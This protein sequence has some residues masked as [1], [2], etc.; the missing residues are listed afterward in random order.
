MA[1]NETKPDNKKAPEGAEQPETKKAKMSVEQ[2]ADSE[3]PEAWFVSIQWFF[4]HLLHWILDITLA[5][6]L[7]L[8]LLLLK[9][10]PGHRCCCETAPKLLTVRIVDVNSIS[11]LPLFLYLFCLLYSAPTKLQKMSIIY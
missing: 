6:R 10:R 7:M 11:P 2:S 8:F 5:R 1:D 9:S 3:W 4:N